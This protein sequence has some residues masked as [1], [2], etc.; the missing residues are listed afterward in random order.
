VQVALGQ[1]EFLRV[2]GGDYPTP[3]GTAIRDYIHVMDLAEGHVAAV[4][5]VLEDEKLG[6][7][8]VNLGRLHVFACD[9]VCMSWKCVGAFWQGLHPCTWQKGMGSSTASQ[10]GAGG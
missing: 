8:P 10:V 2:F 9:L 1:R 5:L 7:K 4:K 6:C 3:D